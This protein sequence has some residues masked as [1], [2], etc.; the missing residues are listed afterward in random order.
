[1]DEFVIGILGRSH[2]VKGFVRIKSLSGE[3]R[4]FLKLNDVRIKKGRRSKD[5][6]IESIAEKSEGVLLCKFKGIDNPE[7]IRK[8]TGW[9]MTVPKKMGA[10]L[11]KGEHYVS[12]LKGCMLFS[13]ETEYGRIRDIV[14]GPGGLLVDIQNKDGSYLIPYSS[15]YFGDVDIE[16]KRIELLTPWVL[17]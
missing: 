2:G 4:H 14:D 1:M 7:D 6:S 8:Y 12:D 9:E 13:K 3:T 17:E 15:R 5:L 10:P 11:K 16:N